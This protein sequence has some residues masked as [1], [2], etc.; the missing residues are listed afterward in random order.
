[1][2]R[3]V[4]ITLQ[5]GDVAPRFDLSTEILTAAVGEGGA[6][7][8]EKMVVLPRASAEDLCQMIL[9]EEIGTVVCGGIE[10]EYYQFLVWKSVEV[11]DSVVGPWSRA[12]DLLAKRELAA[13]A[14]LIERGA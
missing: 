5:G 4:L 3:K 13:G 14:V 6:V 10:E 8:E 7:G 1:M 2:T 12:L 11:I 9:R